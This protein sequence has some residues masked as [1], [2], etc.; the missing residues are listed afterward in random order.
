M[1]DLSWIVVP[2]VMVGLSALLIWGM[3]KNPRAQWQQYRHEIE[4]DDPPRER[5]IFNAAG[6][7]RL[8]AQVIELRRMLAGAF[9]VDTPDTIV[10]FWEAAPGARS[11]FLSYR[12]LFLPLKASAR[13]TLIHLEELCDGEIPD[14]IPDFA[15][16]AV[17]YCFV[18]LPGSSGSDIVIKSFPTEH[19]FAH[20]FFLLDADGKLIGLRADPEDLLESFFAD[21][22]FQ[23]RQALLALSQDERSAAISGFEEVV[24]SEFHHESAHAWLAFLLATTGA[25]AVVLQRELSLAGE[26]SARSRISRIVRAG[27]GSTEQMRV[28]ASELRRHATT[29]EVPAPQAFHLLCEGLLVLRQQRFAR[30]FADLVC[31][32]M[33]SVSDSERLERLFD[34][35]QRG[36]QQA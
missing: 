19:N 20:Q 2:F 8:P 16:F 32:E 9:S 29:A 3:R 7:H 14:H 23:F 18:R 1:P 22:A 35:D 15:R 4:G 17:S 28:M 36:A 25:D 34:S 27:L 31:S 33:N 10:S 21:N 12:Q 5:M 24:S 26:F 6:D 11:E 30:A 13:E